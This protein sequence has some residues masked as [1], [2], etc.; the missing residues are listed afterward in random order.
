V[1]PPTL[2]KELESLRESRTVEL[3]EDVDFINLI[4]P[5]TA[6]GQ[7]F[8]APATTVLIRVPR[9]YPDAGPDMF[10]TDPALTLGSGAAPQSADQVETHV[11]RLWRRFSW[12]QGVPWNPSLHTLLSYLEFVAR[13]LR[14]GV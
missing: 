4:L 11:G 14:A 8:N 7:R 12:H 9:A 3:I 5:G 1:L 13:R 6:T 2:A 10:W